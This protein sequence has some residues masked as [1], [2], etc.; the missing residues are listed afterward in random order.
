MSTH[1]VGLVSDPAFLQHE[2]PP[3]HPERPQRLPAC[4]EALEQ[5]GLLARLTEVPARPVTTAEAAQVHAA[6]YLDRLDQCRGQSGQL[7]PDTF[8]SPHSQQAAA[9]AAGGG[10]DLVR[11]V[12]ADELGAGLALVRPP[13]HHA[14]RAGAM[15]SCLLNNLAVAA[16]AVL[17]EQQRV[18]VVDFDVHHGNGTQQIFYQE[19]GV[20]FL[21]AHRRGGGF[22]PGSGAASETGAGAG[23]GATRNFPLGA[24][25]GTAQYLELFK[26]GIEPALER[27][28]PDLL[29]VSA[30]Y[31]AHQRDPLGGMQLDDQ[32]YADLAMRLADRAHALCQGRWVAFLEGGYDLQG[33][34]RGVTSLTGALLQR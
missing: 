28:C 12:L 3:G 19:P 21:S 4:T 32:G 27:F 2:S 5:A 11:G 22:F 9:L 29:L 26:D 16:A 24:G 13:G 34:S 30:G 7:D 18:A 33:L 10:V 6:A 23:A 25:A 14:T 20:L 17:Q 1:D 8:Y 31:D 15:G